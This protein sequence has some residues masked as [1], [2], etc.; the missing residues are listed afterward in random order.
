MFHWFR[1]RR[2]LRRF[3]VLELRPGDTIVLIAREWGLSVD[4]AL[5]I[6]ADVQREFGH[7][8]VVLPPFDVA[9]IR[10]AHLAVAELPL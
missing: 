8:V 10:E 6:Q 2:V 9:A 7:R 1:R 5:A 3:E 4:H